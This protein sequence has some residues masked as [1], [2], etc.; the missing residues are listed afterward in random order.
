MSRSEKEGRQ[1]KAHGRGRVS[2]RTEAGV[3]FRIAVMECIR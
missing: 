2:A 1:G 3:V